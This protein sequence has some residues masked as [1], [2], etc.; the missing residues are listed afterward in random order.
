MWRPCKSVFGTFLF[1][2]CLF[3]P[4]I[5]CDPGSWFSLLICDDDSQIYISSPFFSPAPPD[6][7][8]QLFPVVS[9]MTNIYL[10]FSMPQ[11][12][13][14][15]LPLNLLHPQPSSILLMTVPSFLVVQT[16]DFGVM[17][18]CS[19][20]LIFHISHIQSV[21]YI[22]NISKTLSFFTPLLLLAYSHSL[23]FLT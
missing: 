18:G 19:H 17:L 22:Q 3:T 16:K 14:L 10:K 5:Y 20:S 11:I 8:I 21:K 12:E 6:S 4:C 1:S 9:L 23:S 13:L 7:L 15:L 2:V